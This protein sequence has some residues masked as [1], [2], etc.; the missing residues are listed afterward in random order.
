MILCTARV[1]PEKAVFRPALPLHSLPEFTGERM[2][3]KLSFAEQIKH[4][5]WQKKRLEVLESAGWECENCGVKDVT[6]NVH[7]KQYVKGRMYWEYDRHE[8]ECLCEDCHKDHHQTQDALKALLAEVDVSEAFAV[9]AGWHEH[10][11]WIDPENRYLGRN[12]NPLAYSAGFIAWLVY[13][14]NIGQMDQVAAY[15]VSLMRE[16]SEARLVYLHNS[17]HLFGRDK[18]V[19][20]E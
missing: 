12:G 2:A 11:D 4:P 18:E 6:L 16:S 17:A 20:D 13:H 3:S 8:L 1:A 15:A 19:G 9:V 14:L 10:S 5:N 7:H